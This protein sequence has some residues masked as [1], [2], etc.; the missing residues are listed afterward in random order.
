MAV[1]EEKP[2]KRPSYRVVSVKK[3]RAPEGMGG[4]NWHCYIIARG[5]SV[6]TGQKPGTLK[7]VTQHAE[8]VAA[9]LNARSGVNA[10]SPYAPRKSR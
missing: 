5:S 7:A 4:D 8:Q 3:T 6:V 9:D 1:A 10:G 2:T